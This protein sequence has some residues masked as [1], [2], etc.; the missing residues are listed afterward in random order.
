MDSDD[1]FALMSGLGWLVSQR[2]FVSRS[3]HLF[4]LIT[5]TILT[6]RPGA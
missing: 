3:D 4:N 2:A 6:N 1:L 5:S